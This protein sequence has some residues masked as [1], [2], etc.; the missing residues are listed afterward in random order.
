MRRIL[1]ALAPA[2]LVVLSAGCAPY[3]TPMTVPPQLTPAQ[4]NFDAC[5]EATLDVLN[6]Y[7]FTVDRAD[8][9]EGVITTQPLVAQHWFEFWRKDAVTAYDLAE[10][11]LQ[12]IFR[13]VTVKIM[14]VEDKTSKSVT[15]RPVVRVDVSQSERGEALISS[16]V[17]AYDMFV[18]PGREEDYTR[19][20]HS[21]AERP[22]ER[23]AHATTPQEQAT[24]VS[25]GTQNPLAEKIAHDIVKNANR[26]L[27]TRR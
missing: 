13:T 11:S 24:I 16:T 18:L 21:A 4:R 17:D 19:R 10:G 2:A 6:E 25:L 14:A 15:Y 26:R 8:R 9:R 12:K 3:S 20:K 5:W 7:Y 27:A 1:T 22:F 23:I